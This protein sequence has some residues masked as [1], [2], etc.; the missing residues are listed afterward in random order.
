MDSCV[1]EFPGG[2]HATEVFQMVEDNF[3]KLAG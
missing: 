3:A 2:Y 1:Q